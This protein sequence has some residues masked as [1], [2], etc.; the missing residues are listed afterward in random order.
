[1]NFL[2]HLKR[3]LKRTGRTSN[4]PPEVEGEAPPGWYDEIYRQSESFRGHYRKSHYYF[5][6]AVIADRLR[7]ARWPAVLEVGC[8][9]GQLGRLLLDQGLQDYAGFDF[10]PV[11][12]TLAR[13]RLP[14]CTIWEG[15]ALDPENYTR[16]RYGAVVCTEVLE[17]VT[18]DFK[19]LAG[20][21]WG[22]YCLCTVPSFDYPSHVR[23]FRDEGEVANRYSAFFTDFSVTGWPGPKGTDDDRFFLFEGRR[24]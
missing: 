22:T 9:P 1:M 4:M 20:I 21:A 10:S 19:V 3:T 16:T 5:L 12:V 23:H 24:I 17:H 11:A 13:T 7:R 14:G 6:W 18:E 2:A 8:G 15:N